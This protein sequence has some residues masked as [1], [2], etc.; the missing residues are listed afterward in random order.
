MSTENDDQKLMVLRVIWVSL[1]SACGMYFVVAMAA[2]GRAPIGE[3]LDIIRV[4]FIGLSAVL[5]LLSGY[6]KRL[7]L[8]KGGPNA[9]YLGTVLSLSMCE[10]P[11]IMGLM[12]RLMGGDANTFYFLA[13][14]AMASL[15]Y[16]FPRRI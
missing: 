8:Q 4:L 1:L 6:V 5:I 7:I 14:S 9:L 16:Y 2:G 10:A 3:G 12:F 11:A 13:A 15:I